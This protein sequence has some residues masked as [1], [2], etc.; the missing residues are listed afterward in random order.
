MPTTTQMSCT[1]ATECSALAAAGVLLQAVLNNAMASPNV[2]G[3]N[4][5]AGLAALCAAAL[6]P[7]HPNAVQ[8]AAFA[9]ALA[10]ALLVYGLALGA[11]VSRTTLVLAGLAVSGMLTAGMNTIKLLYPDAI[12]GASDF[13]VG[14]LSGVTLSGLKGAV[15]YLI[16]GTLLALLLAA[17][18][19]VLCL[20]EQSAAS[21]GLH[22]GAVRFLGILAAALLAGLPY[23]PGTH[24]DAYLAQLF[25]ALGALGA[26]VVTVTGVRPQPDVIGNVACDCRTGEMHASMRPAHPGLFYG[27]GDVFASA[28]AG[29]L[30]RGA[31]LSDA[32]E[33]ATA[34]T[35]ESICRSLW[36]DTPR[37]FGVDFEGALPAYIRRVEKI[38][39]T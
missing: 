33:T 8:P 38:F 26:G 30:V 35:D 14:G 24:S 13:L 17:D 29:L 39:G 15:L 18:L 4:A 10:A 37:H 16:T 3:V 21:L 27:T 6:W 34:L 28:L 25:R 1:S 19:N 22:I 11:G 31:P 2:I 9:G 12:A 5:G 7:T 23:E 32:L 36:R 20:G